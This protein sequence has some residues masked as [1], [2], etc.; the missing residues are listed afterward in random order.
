MLNG[1]YF[2]FSYSSILVLVIFYFK[3]WDNFQF[4]KIIF[5]HTISNSFFFPCLIS[6]LLIG[7]SCKFINVNHQ[8]PTMLLGAAH[9][10]LN[11]YFILRIFLEFF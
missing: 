11:H 9:A 5:F 1:Y 2:F 10:P 6:S 8:G 4:L 7:F 3:N